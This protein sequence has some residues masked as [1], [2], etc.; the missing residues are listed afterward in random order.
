M[1]E[2]GVGLGVVGAGEIAKITQWSTVIQTDAI[3]LA[4]GFAG[5]VGIVFGFYP[6]RRASR[7]DPIEALRR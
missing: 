6:A 1:A 3:A 7:L 2:S 5:A 4:L